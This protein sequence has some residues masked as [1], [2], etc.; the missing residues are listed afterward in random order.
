[1]RGFSSSPFRWLIVA[2]FGSKRV[3]SRPEEAEF[4]VA[5]QSACRLQPFPGQRAA[6][7]AS[8]DALRSYNNSVNIEDPHEISS[9]WETLAPIAWRL[10]PKGRSPFAQSRRAGQSCSEDI[11]ATH[12]GFFWKWQKRGETSAVRD[13]F[14]SQRFI[15]AAPN[16]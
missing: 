16:A 10:S 2:A 7:C 13:G 15:T 14:N 11:L 12:R 5:R 9:I 8:I 3:H 1:M 6:G 4:P